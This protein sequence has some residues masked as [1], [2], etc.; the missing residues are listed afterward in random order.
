DV[1]ARFQ[2]FLDD[3]DGQTGFGSIDLEVAATA[4]RRPVAAGAPIS[5][6]P[7]GV[8]ELF[9]HCLAAARDYRYRIHRSQR[10]LTFTVLGAAVGLALLAA[11]AGGLYFAHDL[12][13]PVPLVAAVE[14]YRAREGQTAA[15]RLAEPLQRKISELSGLQQSPDFEKLPPESKEFVN[16]RLLELTA[17]RKYRD[18]LF[19]LR[20][21][22]DL[23]SVQE[24]TEFE[25]RL[26]E[27]FDPPKEYA[28]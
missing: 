8:A 24:A 11:G 5:R 21:P 10:R 22:G 18:Q 2:E 9:R 25:T 7:L 12:T 20:P 28:D 15:E 26:K 17:Y 6:E 23:R 16:Q 4:V 14:G 1:M 19:E 3:D 27:R 13:K